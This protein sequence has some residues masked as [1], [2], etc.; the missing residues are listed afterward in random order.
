MTKEPTFPLFVFARRH[1]IE[2]EAGF[3]L[4]G[5]LIVDIPK[6]L[7]GHR[8]KKMIQKIIGGLLARSSEM[9]DDALVYGWAHG[10]KPADAVNVDDDAQMAAWADRCV[11]IGVRIDP[12][13]DGK[14]R[15]DSDLERQLGLA[16][17]H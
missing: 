16:Q 8:Q 2:I 14:I 4:A 6:G 13:N 3:V 17:E 12:R 9:P 5:N 15:V 1:D 7:M 10:A 11:K